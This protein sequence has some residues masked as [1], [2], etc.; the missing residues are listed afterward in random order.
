MDTLA[1]SYIPEQL[2]AV[3]GAAPLRW[4]YVDLNSYFASVEQQLQPRLRGRPV[5]VVPVMSDSSCAIAASYEAKAFGV[6]TGTRIHEA[7]RLC[8]GLVCVPARH[9]AYVDYHHRVIEEI[10]RHIPVSAVCSIDEVACRLMANEAPAEIAT[11]IARAIKSGIAHRVGAELRCSIG[12]AP[13]RYLAKVATELE[14]PDGLVVLDANDL[15]DALHGLPLADLPGIGRNMEARLARAGISDMRALLG[16]SPVHMRRL[17]GTVWGERMWLLLRGHDLP[18]LETERRSIGHSRIMAPELRVPE[19]ARL[20]ARRLV[21]KAAS[22]LRR[23]GYCARALHLA[24]RLEHGPRLEAGGRFWRAR[25]NATF[26]AMLE[27]LW[28]RLAEARRDWRIKKVSITLHGLVATTA[29]EPDLFDGAAAAALADRAKA[30]KISQAFDALNRRFGRDTVLWGEAPAR[31][32][33][34]AAAG[35]DYL[36]SKIAFTRIPDREE[37]WE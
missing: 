24:L 18:E 5:A 14:K 33:E 8:P 37:F 27:Q 2:A 13:S 36:G 20:V 34:E 25:D 32:A 23:M 1:R 7:R 12:I 22:R 21:L 6:R 16:L 30:E 9:D 17:W 10:D 3:G 28:E 35:L 11:A 31:R 29:L 19:K 26:L 15:P 4:L